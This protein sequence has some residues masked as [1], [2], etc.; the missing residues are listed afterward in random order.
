MAQGKF[1]ISHQGGIF[2]LEKRAFQGGAQGVGA[3]QDHHLHPGFFGG[4]KQQPQGPEIGIDPAAHVLQV[5]QKEVQISQ[6]LR[7][8]GQTR[9]VKAI[10]RQSGKGVLSVRGPDHVGLFGAVET[11]LRG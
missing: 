11:V 4:G 9:A 1:G 7:G 8:G 2:R 3:V 5:H 10:Y 6:H